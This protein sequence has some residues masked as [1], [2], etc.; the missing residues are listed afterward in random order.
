MVLERVLQVC[1]KPKFFSDCFKGIR[2]LPIVI[3]VDRLLRRL[4]PLEVTNMSSVLL[5][6]SLSMF[7]VAQALTSLMHDCIE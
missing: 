1:V 5:T 7:A 3:E 4:V 2:T 6:L